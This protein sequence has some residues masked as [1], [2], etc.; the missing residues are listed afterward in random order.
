MADD[1]RSGGKDAPRDY[2]TPKTPEGTPPVI[3]PDNPEK[4]GGTDKKARE[5]LEKRQ[6]RRTNR[7]GAGEE[8]LDSMNP[9]TLLPPD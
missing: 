8:E 4:S 2:D 9:E 3:R 5:E 1:N 6:R 7:E